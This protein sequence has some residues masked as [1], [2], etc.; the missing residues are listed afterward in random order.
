M[1]DDRRSAVAVVVPCRAI[2]AVYQPVSRSHASTARPASS[3]VKW[4]N[5]KTADRARSVSPIRLAFRAVMRKSGLSCCHRREVAHPCERRGVRCPR[6]QG[7]VESREAPE[8]RDDHCF[9]EGRARDAVD[10]RGFADEGGALLQ[11]RVASPAAAYDG[12]VSA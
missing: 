7:D 11:D 10:G 4:L 9:E 3:A 5:R 12:R 6:Q 8:R 1:A 2:L